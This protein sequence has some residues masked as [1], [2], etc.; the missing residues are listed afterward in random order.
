MKKN[1]LIS[2]IVGIFIVIFGAYFLN[3][4]DFSIDSMEKNL[5]TNYR[6]IKVR[7]TLMLIIIIQRSN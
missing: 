6:I 5:R 3:R 2:A 7:I 4:R 1:V